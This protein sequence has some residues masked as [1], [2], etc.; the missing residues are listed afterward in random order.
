MSGSSPKFFR[1]ATEGAT[2]DGRVI[3]RQMLLQM[4]DS[5]DPKTYGARINLEHIRGIDPSGLFKAYGDVTAL[6]AEEADGKMRLYAQLDPT[7]ELIALS[8]AKQ[9]VYCSMEVNPDFAD[10]GE[11]YLVALAVT[12]NPASLGCEMLQFSTKAKVNPLAERKQDPDNVF[13]EAVAIDLDFSTELNTPTQHSGLAASIK[14]LFARQDKAESGNTAQHADA[15]EAVQMLAAEIKQMGQSFTK[16]TTA[17]E[18]IASQVDAIQTE[19]TKDKAEF[20]SLKQTLESTEN[21]SR[22]PTATGGNGDADI[23]TDC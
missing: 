13:S 3:D 7:Q 17:L 2:S 23:K 16:V 10:S 21:Y 6:K 15:H 14:R 20:S 9:K 19:Q 12:D 8:K 22:R 5:Y 1:I 11:A 18:S 4:A